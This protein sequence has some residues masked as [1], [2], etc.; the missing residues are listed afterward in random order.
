MVTG[1]A[2]DERCMWHDTGLYFGPKEGSPW[3]E[4]IKSPE[5]PQGKRRIKN[6]LDA[7]GLT[8]RLTPIDVE[9]A[10]SKDILRVHT[11]KYM[12]EVR[13]ISSNGGGNL[14][15]RFGA[16]RIGQ[17]G[18]DIALLAAGGAIASVK[19]VLD[20]EV[21]NAYALIRPPGHH[22]EPDEAMGFCVFSNA[23]LSGMYAISERELDRVAFVDWDVHHGNG[24]QAV[25]WED[26]RALTVSI[27]QENNFPPGSGG[28]EEIGAKDGTGTAINI[29]LP[30][31]SGEAV[32]LAAFDRVVLPALSLYQPQLIIVPC[33]FDAG[34]HDPLGR[35]M[36]TSESF[37]KLAQKIKDAAADI[38]DSKLVLTHEGGYAPHL[39]PFHCLAVLEQLSGTRTEVVDP[40]SFV[41]DQASTKCILSHE[42]EAIERAEALLKLIPN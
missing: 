19:A 18:L 9:A 40:W 32:Y 20:G 14:A 13:R 8:S 29:P 2:W 39:V 1:L 38:C 10:S 28:I 37:R 36:L 30:P 24:T 31:G 3:I 25:F 21:D 15:R 6:L 16:T 33:G 5:N 35:M 27:H 12:E 34:F 11:P 17:G 23:A 7:S 41:A 26:P 4:P 42:T 22:A